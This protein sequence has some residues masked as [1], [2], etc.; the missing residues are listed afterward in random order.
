[1]GERGG[2]GGQPPAPPPSTAGSPPVS[3]RRGYSLPL[4]FTHLGTNPLKKKVLLFP[5]T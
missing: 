3:V 2:D 4:K 1:M 5:R